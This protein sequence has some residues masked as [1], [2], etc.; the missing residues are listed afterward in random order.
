M[1]C[2]LNKKAHHSIVFFLFPFGVFVVVNVLLFSFLNSVAFLH[3]LTRLWVWWAQP[4]VL[5]IFDARSFFLSFFLL[6]L[7]HSISSIGISIHGQDGECQGR[8]YCVICCSF[9]LLKTWSHYLVLF[10]AKIVWG[11]I[12]SAKNFPLCLLMF[13]WH[14]GRRISFPSRLFFA[15]SY[16][17]VQVIIKWLDIN[18]CI[19]RCIVAD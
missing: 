2:L 1:R 12:Q 7:G 15:T 8:H 17:C 6:I 18:E 16:K 4:C 3:F 5:Y 11:S 13:I 14:P 10:H 9:I 19:F